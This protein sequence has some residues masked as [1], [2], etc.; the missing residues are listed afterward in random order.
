[1]SLADLIDDEIHA[2]A[3]RIKALALFG[4]DKS[5]IMAAQI[6]EH[7]SFAKRVPKNALAFEFAR[8][9]SGLPCA[10]ALFVLDDGSHA[11]VQVHDLA[12]DLSHLHACFNVQTHLSQEG[13]WLDD[14]FSS[15]VPKI[16]G[17]VREE[18]GRAMVTQ[19][20]TS[21]AQTP[22]DET[23]LIE[24]LSRG[25]QHFS[26]ALSSSTLPFGIKTYTPQFVAEEIDDAIKHSLKHTPEG[27]FVL[28]HIA[29]HQGNVVVDG[30]TKRASSIGG[31]EALFYID[32][33]ALVAKSALA[34]GDDNEAQAEPNKAQVQYYIKCYQSARGRAFTSDERTRLDAFLALERVL[35][36]SRAK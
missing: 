1:M 22:I 14:D 9:A 30:A 28:G 16:L 2:E 34:F 29:F 5:E 25:L 15:E 4:H 24:V 19:M 23:T 3:G 7:L 27:N 18:M 6:D 20:L 17:P 8:N 31:F 11:E 12:A 33:C 21:H 36:R 13:L 35:R 32:E 10:K 26:N